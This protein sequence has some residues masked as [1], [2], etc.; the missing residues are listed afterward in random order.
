M[1]PEN[2]AMTIYSLPRLWAER[3]NQSFD[4][5]KCRKD[6]KGSLTVVFKVKRVMRSQGSAKDLRLY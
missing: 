6:L 3:P 1:L 2:L 5:G 4:E